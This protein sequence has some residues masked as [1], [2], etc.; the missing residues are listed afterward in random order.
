M[1]KIEDGLWT[2]ARIHQYP[3]GGG[4]MGIHQDSILSGVSKNSGLD[5]FQLLVVMS[6]KNEDFEQG[7]SFVEL[8]GTRI[9]LEDESELG[10]I[11]IYDGST[12]HGVADIDP[13]KILNLNKINGRLAG[14]VSLYKDLK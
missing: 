14:F 2:A 3:L 5:Y 1:D 4:F 8:D 9:Y 6:K 13:F 11:I 10:D 12:S 7:G